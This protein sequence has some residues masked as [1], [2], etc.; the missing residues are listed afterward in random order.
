M[1]S[2]FYRFFAKREKVHV[3]ITHPEYKSKESLKKRMTGKQMDSGLAKSNKHQESRSVAFG[4][5]E[6]MLLGL[7]EEYDTSMLGQSEESE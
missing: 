3:A 7:G 2:F 5:Q 1:S 6:A 4:K